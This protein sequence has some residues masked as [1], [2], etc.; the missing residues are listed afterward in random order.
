[1]IRLVARLAALP[2]VI[3]VLAMT[4]STG[5]ARHHHSKRWKRHHRSDCSNEI[6]SGRG[7]DGADGRDDDD[8]RNGRNVRV[9]RSGANGRDS[10]GRLRIS[11]NCDGRGSRRNNNVKRK[12]SNSVVNEGGA[13]GDAGNQNAGGSINEPSSGGDGGDSVGSVSESNDC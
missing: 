4:V 7:R 3:A 9:R 13:G 1:M 5:V 6:R 10:R 12:C 11:N 2:L 8:S